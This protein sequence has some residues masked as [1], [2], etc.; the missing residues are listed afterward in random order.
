MKHIV[1]YRREIKDAG[2]NSNNS[3]AVF[4]DFLQF[5][6]I[7]QRAREYFL[8]TVLKT[9]YVTFLPA[10]STPENL[11]TWRC[12]TGICIWKFKHAKTVG[13]LH[14]ATR[15]NK[16]LT[17]QLIETPLAVA[18]GNR[19]SSNTVFHTVLQLEILSYLYFT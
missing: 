8:H 18:K 2:Q 5:F 9:L 13:S 6:H 19:P 11:Y 10:P 3:A 4:H 17:A 1:A 15:P 14:I 12:T 7:Y 16:H